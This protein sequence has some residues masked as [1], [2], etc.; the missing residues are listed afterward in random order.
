M[1][2]QNKG[3]FFDPK[4]ITA[5]VLVGAVWFGWQTYLTKKYPDYNKPKPKETVT[6]AVDVGTQ[7]ATAATA[8]QATVETQSTPGQ[9]AQREFEYQDSNISFKITSHGM[10][11]KNVIL[12]Q[13][14]DYSKNPIKVGQSDVSGLFELK[15]ISQGRPL[16]FDLKEESPGQYVGI[17]QVGETT[18]I[19]TL[20]YDS[21]KQAFSN[22]V[23]INNVSA[24]AAQGL[25]LLIPEKVTVPESS[26]WLFP[27]YEHQDFFVGHNGK[28]ETVNF[29]AAQEDVK[30]GFSGVS[31]VSVSSQYFAAAILDR[32]EIIP[33]TMIQ[34][35]VL[36][37]TASAE[38]LYK[39]AQS[40]NQISLQQILFVGPK[41]IDTLK[42]VD[43]ELASVI[44]HGF[45][46]F[47]A[48]PL[49]Y[50]MKAFHGV[51]GNWGLAII[52]LTLLVRLCVLPFA[53]MSAKSMKAMQKIQP[54][55]QNLREKYKD[56]AMALN[57]ETM[58]LMK[59]HKANPIGG[60]LPMLL[61][62]PV[63]FALYRVIG[64]S[65]EL[66]HSPFYGWIGDLSS[67]DKFFVLPILMGLTMFLQQKMTPTT[68]DPAQA[69]ILA[70]LPL[71]FTVFMLQLPSGL[72]L[73]MTV[74]SVFGIVQQYF[75]LKDSKKATA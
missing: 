24:E 3:S 68:M 55:L 67:P 22:Q 31:L 69:K 16:D 7:A 1:Q 43:P 60:C 30:Q 74:S 27:S 48:R 72:T 9:I 36:A 71:V 25:L 50:I 66:Y 11:L 38:L 33:E 56:D 59:E 57:R 75:F 52:C 49:L 10:G 13:F 19:R 47:I 42:N 8:A 62:I 35:A 20:K 28:T 15:L 21:Q 40:S 46:A 14:T 5:V 73:Y 29:S 70:F 39:P 18:V 61:Q 12:N 34:S 58:A 44:D 51:M 23:T 63:F 65:I 26:S 41:S 45:F 17:A 53:M 4:T 2:T 6:H 32:S 54:L 64:S 37:K